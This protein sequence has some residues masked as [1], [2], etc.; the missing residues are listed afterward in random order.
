M[1][2]QQHQERERGL[3]GAALRPFVVLMGMVV[4]GGRRNEGGGGQHVSKMM[5]K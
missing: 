3:L 1:N 2:F 4:G 5:T